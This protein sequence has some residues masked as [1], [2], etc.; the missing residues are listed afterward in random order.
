MVEPAAS[1]REQRCVF[2]DIVAG[3]APA[4]LVHDDGAVVAFMDHRPVTAGHLLVV[5]REHQQLITELDPNTFVRLA[6][7]GRQLDAA[8]RTAP[9]IRCDAVS[10]YVA[11]AATGAARRRGARRASGLNGQ[12]RARCDVTARVRSL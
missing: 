1:S 4:S 6:S 11:D 2:C 5:S 8:L 12:S 10:L 7:V 9:A 3:R